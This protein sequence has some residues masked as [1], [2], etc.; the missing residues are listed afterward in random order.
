MNFFKSFTHSTTTL[1]PRGSNHCLLTSSSTS[2]LASAD[3]LDIAEL[4][5]N[6]GGRLKKAD[7]EWPLVCLVHNIK[8]IYVRIMAKGGELDKLTRELLADYNVA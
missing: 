5:K 2:N 7:G 1:E 4:L 3:D 6:L 8:K